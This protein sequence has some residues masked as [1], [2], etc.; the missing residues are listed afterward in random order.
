MWTFQRGYN[1][2][3]KTL[4]CT[5]SHKIICLF[6]GFLFVIFLL[7]HYIYTHTAP[8]LNWWKIKMQLKTLLNRVHA[9]S[10]CHYCTF[11]A[12]LENNKHN[13]N[14]NMK[15]YSSCRFQI[16]MFSPCLCVKA[17]IK[18]TGNPKYPSI[19]PLFC[20]SPTALLIQGC[21]PSA[22]SIILQ[23]QFT[24]SWSEFVTLAT[25]FSATIARFCRSGPALCY[26]SHNLHYWDIWG[27]FKAMFVSL[28]LIIYFVN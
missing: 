19:I 27:Y 26:L 25:A 20:W 15:T 9:A 5:F 14:S 24:I 7:S 8:C 4:A 22:L 6:V 28:H 2:V 17:S 18:L 13:G 12:S 23:Q 16:C 3:S 11:M 10:D 21:F 1:N